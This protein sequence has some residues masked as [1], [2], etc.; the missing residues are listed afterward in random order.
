MQAIDSITLNFGINLAPKLSTNFDEIGLVLMVSLWT[1]ENLLKYLLS[2]HIF[3]FVLVKMPNSAV[4]DPDDY[5]GYRISI[6]AGTSQPKQTKIRSRA[7]ATSLIRNIVTSTAVTSEEDASASVSHQ[8]DQN[9][10]AVAAIQSRPQ[11]VSPTAIVSANATLTSVPHESYPATSAAAVA[12]PIPQIV[13]PAAV[14]PGE[15]S[16]T[17]VSPKAYRATPTAINMQSRP[18]QRR[19][20]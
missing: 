3:P 10:P 7:A 19:C 16:L 20:K 14:T 9:T 8:S 17:S 5:S 1:N 6:R 12:T 13:S 4:V 11:I 2:C 18:Q 15:G